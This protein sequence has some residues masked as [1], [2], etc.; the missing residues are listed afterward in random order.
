[1]SPLTKTT[2]ER[3]SRGALESVRSEEKSAESMTRCGVAGKAMAFSVATTLPPL[4]AILTTALVVVP[5]PAVLVVVTPVTGRAAL[6]TF[7]AVPSLARAEIYLPLSTVP[8]ETEEMVA[9]AAADTALSILALTDAAVA[10]CSVRTDQSS[11]AA[12]VTIPSICLILSFCMILSF[13]GVNNYY[14]CDILLST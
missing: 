2:T 1:M 9:P 6:V 10:S 14:Q 11:E 13:L 5:V 3:V 12:G 8:P 4:S 7:R